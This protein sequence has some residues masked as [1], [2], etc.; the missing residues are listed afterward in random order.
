MNNKSTLNILVDHLLGIVAPLE[1]AV[2]NIE[3]FQ[4]FIYRLGYS[5]DDVP[6]QFVDLVVSIKNAHSAISSLSDVSSLSEVKSAVEKAGNVYRSIN[7]VNSV[8]IGI[9]ND[10]AADFLKDL[11]VKLFEL[12]SMDYLSSY[13]P[14]IYNSFKLLNI[15]QSDYIN[16]K[17]GQVGHIRSRFVASEIPEVLGKPLDL[18]RRIY[19][20]GESELNFSLIAE[21]L[22]NLLFSLGLPVRIVHVDEDESKGFQAHEDEPFD[23]HI[24]ERLSIM[25]L[26]DVIETEDDLDDIPL[27]AGIN[28]MEMPA[29]GISLAGIIIQPDITED[30]GAEIDLDDNWKLSVRTEMDLASKFGICITPDDIFLRYPF[31]EGGNFPQ[32][33]FN[34]D[35]SYSPDK[36]TVLLGQEGKSRLQILGG[37]VAFNIDYVNNDLD[38]RFDASVFDLS[39][40]LATSDID[41]FLSSL[42]SGEDLKVK[43][44]LGLSWSNRT[45]LDFTAGLGLT[46]VTY[47]HL[48]LGP[49]VVDKLN[50]QVETNFIENEPV[51]LNTIAGLTFTGELGPVKFAFDNM[52]VALDFVFAEGN[53]GPFDIDYKFKWPSQVGIEVDAGAV[54]GGGYLSID[55]EKGEYI[56]YFTLNINNI[57]LTATGILNTKDTDGKALPA[58]GFSF[59]IILTSEFPPIQL[60]YGFTL[61][62][63]GGLAGIHRT[64]VIDAMQTGLRNGSL[65]SLLSPNVKDAPALVS[66]IKAFFPVEIDSYV[67]GPIAFLGWGSPT[68]VHIK[69]GIILKLPSPVLLVLIG[70]ILVELPEEGDKS[71]VSLKMD[72]LGVIDFDQKRISLDATLRE[73]SR[74]AAFALSGDMAMRLNYSDTNPNFAL[75]VGGL[76]SNFK[77]PAGFPTL[78]RITVALGLEENPRITL[79]GYFAITSNS[80]QFGARAELFAGGKYNVH[81]WIFFDALFI[82]TPFSFQVDIA[83]GFALRRGSKRIAGIHVTATL[84]GP[85]PYH[86]WGEGCISI[87]FFDVCVGFDQTFGNT[88][89]Q[90]A[91]PPSDPWDLLKPALEDTK[92]WSANLPVTVVSAVSLKAAPKDES[93]IILIHPM[94]NITL[95]Q[96]AVPLFRILE[97][98]GENSLDG[99]NRY[100]ISQV[101]VGGETVSWRKVYDKFAPR[102]V[103]DLTKA[104]MISRP[105]FE[106]MVAGFE[107]DNSGVDYGEPI[108]TQVEYETKIIDRPW[109]I[110]TLRE[111]FSPTRVKQLAWTLLGAKS[112]S[113]LW[114]SGNKK[115]YPSLTLQK[116]YKVA[117]EDFVVVSTDDMTPNESLGTFRT[118]GEALQALKYH[119]IENPQVSEELQVVS[120]HDLREVA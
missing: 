33:N 90:T 4:A 14:K 48:K 60:G 80:L 19:G 110:R 97:R 120:M 49:I 113:S 118:K 3:K 114:K 101:T 51:Q 69:L 39:M 59:L 20:W 1:T 92:N 30:F 99:A 111:R 35:L 102:L 87:L 58:P 88:K 70:Q 17:T 36:P 56:G 45:G 42:F 43:I 15:I 27:Y 54:K 100:S 38:F 104:E 84:T 21:H 116:G 77:A 18:P 107:L 63:V 108:L 7:N 82:F 81:G 10:L 23:N 5:V 37:L 67:F 91:L 85:N 112:V 9:S 117:N 71:I 44:P 24:N 6:D 73:G 52:G 103:E 105:S 31:Q 76:N 72:L 89:P 55:S 74:I 57:G 22:Y 41:G 32:A 96:K 61:N 50:L 16:S 95:R 47:P 2:S 8:P 64:M 12:L 28:I 68:L 26:D 83:A 13:Q 98:L 115:Y 109:S 75:S 62:G 53:A 94:G 40:I 78:R 106:D 29:E 93:D 25:L 86:V 46:V 66:G 65:G 79:Q 119:E 11:G 34:L